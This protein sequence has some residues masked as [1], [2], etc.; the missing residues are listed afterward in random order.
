MQ[1]KRGMPRKA[2]YSL[3]FLTLL[4]IGV[5]FLLIK[6]VPPPTHTIEQQLENSVFTGDDEPSAN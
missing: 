6:E 1:H 3:T 4:A 5:V 2:L